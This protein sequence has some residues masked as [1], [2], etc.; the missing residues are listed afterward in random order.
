MSR[1]TKHKRLPK[2]Q[3]DEKGLSPP[4]TMKE[5][6]E[7]FGGCYETLQIKWE[8]VDTIKAHCKAHK[9]SQ[10]KLASMVPGL[11]QDRVSHFFNYGTSG[12]ITIDKLIE[13]AAAL[14]IKFKL[15]R[16]AA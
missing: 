4:M 11:S 10:R 7:S 3:Y 15:V 6:V 16:K 1:N 8:L 5:F 13:I 2:I 14:N 9:I 12:G